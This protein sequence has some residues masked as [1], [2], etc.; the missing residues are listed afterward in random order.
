MK[1]DPSAGIVV[2]VR[3]LVAIALAGCGRFGFEAPAEDALASDT[4]GADVMAGPCDP[5]R[6]LCD[7]FEGSS[8]HARWLSPGTG[9]TLDSTRAHRGTSSLHAHSDALAVGVDGY[10]AISE[11]TVLPQQDATVHVRAW[12]QFD[13]MPL[14]NMGMIAAVQNNAGQ[15]EVGVFL[16]STALTVYSQFEERSRETPAPPA[17]STWLCLQWTIVRSQT[18]GSLTLAGDAGAAALS[19]VQTEGNAGLSD[20][21]IGI[22]FAGDSVT[23]PQPAMDVWIDDLVVSTAPITC[24]D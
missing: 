21:E 17:L 19:S 2:E 7:G 3:W 15:T 24:A 1:L 18:N 23:V 20:F 13:Q 8:L 11:S 12:V 4:N 22:S 9:I 16:I 10:V 14:N 5:P 6:K